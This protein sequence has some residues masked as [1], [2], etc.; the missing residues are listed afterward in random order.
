MLHTVTTYIHDRRRGMSRAAGYLGGA[1]VLGRYVL[2]R[3]DDIRSKVIQDRLARENLRRRFEQN[4]QDVSY[5]IMALLPTLG[6]HILDGMDVEGVTQELQSLSKTAKARP[7]EFQPPDPPSDASLASSVA[8]L[9]HDEHEARSDNG[10]ISVVSSNDAAAPSEMSASSS[11]WVDQFSSVRSSD[12]SRQPSLDTADF[13]LH[14]ASPLSESVLTTSSVSSAPQEGTGSSAANSVISESMTSST[15]SKAELWRE[16]KILTFT[17]TLTIIYSVTLLSIFTHIQ[18]NLVGRSKYIHSV[19]QL[20][21]DERMRE[22]IQFNTSVY[23]LLW[24][25]SSPDESDLNADLEGEELLSE[26]TERKFLTLSWWILNVGW[27]DVGERVRRGV[28]E[29]FEGVSL[30]TKLTIN[31]LHRLIADV[32]RRVEY[33]VTFEGKERRINFMSTLLPPTSETLQHVLIQGGIHPSLAA[34]PDVRFEAL[35]A[36]TREWLRSGSFERV[37]EVSLD[38]ATEVLFTGLQR[39][40]F[41]G[42]DDAAS[43]SGS[44]EQPKER[45]A[46]ML[47][48]LARWCHV[49]L[50]GLPNELVDGLAGSRETAALAAI[51]FTSYEDRFR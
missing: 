9:R 33:E 7:L 18:L 21:Q 38:Q 4:Q 39:H 5:T 31:D 29:V 20:E 3:L 42:A 11:S 27:K 14:T 13:R 28:E 48:G 47:P 2:D 19:C 6:T 8:S 17:R 30:K 24:D 49:A 22:R 43:G 23:A 46:A 50:E 10:S 25:D 45:L 37:L 35:L 51:I 44:G 41:G 1:Y 26:E 15:R 40:V 32:R 16:V 34:A 12:L 36:E